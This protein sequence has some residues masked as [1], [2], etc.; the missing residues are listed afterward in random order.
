MCAP[1]DVAM[2]FP[3]C[4]Y[5][6]KPAEIAQSIFVLGRQYLFHG[7][8]GSL[9]LFE[10][11]SPR[12]VPGRLCVTSVT[13]SSLQDWIERCVENRPEVFEEY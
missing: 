7:W 3:P 12:F 2:Q 11:I 9:V 13:V 10:K 6:S 1:Q 5:C 4:A 8:R